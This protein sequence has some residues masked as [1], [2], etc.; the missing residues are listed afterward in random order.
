MLYI[1]LMS[2]KYILCA[3]VDMVQ[4]RATKISS[5][6]LD[7][8]FYELSILVIYIY[9]LWRIN[10]DTIFTDNG[11]LKSFLGNHRNIYNVY[12]RYWRVPYAQVEVLGPILYRLLD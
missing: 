4:I 10:L 5:K 2:W 3:F 1:E 6:I 7:K 11:N 12:K 9:E 8:E